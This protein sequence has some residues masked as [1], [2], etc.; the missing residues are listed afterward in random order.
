M[1]QPENST[2]APEEKDYTTVS[3]HVSIEV[4]T[5]LKAQAAAA[6][7]AN[8]KLKSLSKYLGHILTTAAQR[9]SAQLRADLEASIEAKAAA[10]AQAEGI[11][12]DAAPLARAS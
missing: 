3:A 1:S 10:E 5:A 2:S 7:V 8:P 11:C 9:S 4:A 12:A 6:K